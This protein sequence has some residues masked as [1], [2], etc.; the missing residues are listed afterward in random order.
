[1]INYWAS[2]VHSSSYTLYNLVPSDL[3][4]WDDYN[5]R[6]NRCDIFSGYYHNIAY[7]S[8]V[9]Y[10]QGLKT[11]EGLYK[12]VRGVYNPVNRLVESYVSKVYGGLL[13]T[14]TTQAGSIP[15]QTENLAL[16]EAIKSLWIASKWGQKKSLYVR[17]G[18]MIGDSFIKIVDDVQHEQ[19]RMEVLN[20]AK[21]KNLEVDE[22]GEIQQAVIEY[23][24]THP[25]PGTMTN[26][27]TLYRETITPELFSI[28][29]DGKAV[30]IAQ[31]GRGEM[32][33]EWPN[34]Y[35]FVPLKHVQ[36]T[37]MDMRFGAPAFHGS[38]HKIN[39]L[40]DLASI[41]NDG[42]RK[43]VQLPLVFKNA[44]IGSLDFGSDQSS[45]TVQRNDKPRKD[46][47]NALEITGTD[48]EVIVL[49]PTIDITSG[50]EN[51]REIEFELEKDLPELALHRLRESGNLT[52]PG[53]R[54]AYDDAIARYQE[55][56]GNYD[57]GLVEAHNM[58]IAIGG[59]R[60]YEGYQGFNL[61]S[62]HDGSME[63]QIA[64]RPVISDTL[65]LNEQLT[66]TL[67]GL[68][69]NAPKTFYIR[70]GW[71]EKEADEL[72]ESGQSQR[73][74]FMATNP[75]QTVAETQPPDDPEATAQDVFDAREN[76]G[77]NET[78]LI[79]A[80]ELLAEVA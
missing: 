75:F 54:S 80:G 34:E 39:E 5:S 52:A 38:M 4:A 40:N 12:H 59:F 50:I 35:G 62:L 57:S 18:A 17:N 69:Q 55:A 44:K 71:S 22:T 61:Q 20:P 36:H 33:S 37:D 67:Q 11:T 24:I 43:Q 51:I 45:Q 25:D 15:I 64:Q 13:D 19:V 1:M 74:A 6:L 30:P 48:A 65:G 68:S 47:Q 77:L 41:L 26:K 66:V 3:Y 58:A 27:R 10:S 60:G 63:H 8:F 46:T 9:T 14:E 32:V 7:H 42:M 76:S 29:L 28:T 70:A 31:N 73:N 21:I 56:R 16:I 78:D 2:P 79:G 49:S 72:V 23:W 53:V